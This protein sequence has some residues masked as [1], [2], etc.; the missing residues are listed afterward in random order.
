MLVP[1]SVHCSA[2]DSCRRVAAAIEG[3]SLGFLRPTYRCSQLC[4]WWPPWERPGKD[5]RTEDK[6]QDRIKAHQSRPQ[7][8]T[9]QV[10]KMRLRAVTRP[11]PACA[12]KPWLYFSRQSA[13]SLA[14]R[15][16]KSSCKRWLPYHV[17]HL[18]PFRQTRLSTNK[19][20]CLLLATMTSTTLRKGSSKRTEMVESRIIFTLAKSCLTWSLW[21]LC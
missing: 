5:K 10:R 12:A 20:P 19:S 13:S 16:S 21:T 9:S 8:H 6:R 2:G 4:S 3:A 1:S 11:V 15:K 17:V 18:F 14:A 7:P